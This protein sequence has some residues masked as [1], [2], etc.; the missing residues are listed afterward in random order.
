ML[1]PVRM[2]RISPIK[3]GV[4][5]IDNQPLDGSASLVVR[6]ELNN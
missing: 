1:H 5:G 3:L 2:I 6:M 4:V